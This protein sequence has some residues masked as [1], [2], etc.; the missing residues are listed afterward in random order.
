MQIC[1]DPALKSGTGCKFESYLIPGIVFGKR[2]SELT[3]MFQQGACSI[4]APDLPA[5]S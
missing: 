4:F 2:V 1:C 5:A 3:H